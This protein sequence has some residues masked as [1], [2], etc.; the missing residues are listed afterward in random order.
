[1]FFWSPLLLI[2]AGGLAWRLARGRRQ[3]EPLLL[4]FLGSFLLLWY[5]NSAWV[6]WWFGDSFGGRAYLELSGLFVLGLATAFEA[7]RGAG[8]WARRALAAGVG[9]ALLY[10]LVLMG[11]YITHR[12]PRSDYLF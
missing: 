6:I 9:A 4:C 2:A 7:V 1:L 10:N 11:L 12:I 5:A 3:P 8:P